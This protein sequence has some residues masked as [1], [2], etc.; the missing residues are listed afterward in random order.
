MW[1]GSETPYEAAN[2]HLDFFFFLGLGLRA[3]LAGATCRRC[4]FIT[5]FNFSTGPAI[6]AVSGDNVEVLVDALSA[7][8]STKAKP[9]LPSPDEWDNVLFRHMHFWENS[10]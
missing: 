1:C 10:G 8:L 9:Y 7:L 2:K 4:S 3:T 5:L 6:E